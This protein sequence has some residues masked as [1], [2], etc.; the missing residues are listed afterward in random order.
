M[1][2]RGPHRRLP[3]GPQIQRHHCTE[4]DLRYQDRARYCRRMETQLHIC[5]FR[6]PGHPRHP[7]WVR[8]LQRDKSRCQ[9]CCE[10]RECI[11][12]HIRQT[13]TI[14]LGQ[15]GMGVASGR[16]MGVASLSW[17]VLVEWAWL[18]V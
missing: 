12:C 17:P 15:A 16:S 2:R 14:L 3:C 6:T 18:A 1:G 9:I 13:L 10:S 4:W 5:L 7:E 8:G 11:E